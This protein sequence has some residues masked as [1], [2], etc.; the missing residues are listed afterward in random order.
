MYGLI[1][2]GLLIDFFGRDRGIGIL[3]LREL[4]ISVNFDGAGLEIR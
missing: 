1:S 4:A 2:L 3:A